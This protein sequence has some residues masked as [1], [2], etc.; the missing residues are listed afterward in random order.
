MLFLRMFNQAYGQKIFK[1]IAYS[2][3]KKGILTTYSAKGKVKRA[4]NASG[5]TVENI[6]GP[7]GKREITR[8]SLK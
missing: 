5:F 8:A 6:S 2:M 7:P 3:K 1:K 4:L